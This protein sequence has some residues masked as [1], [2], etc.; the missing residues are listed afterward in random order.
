MQKHPVAKEPLKIAESEGDQ[1]VEVYQGD[2][3]L[4]YRVLPAG[5]PVTAIDIFDKK[6]VRAL[7]LIRTEWQARVG[8]DVFIP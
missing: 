8:G 3:R 4:L 5:A 2:F 1:V 6:D 7:E